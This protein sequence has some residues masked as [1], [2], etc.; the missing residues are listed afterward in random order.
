M[1][2]LPEDLRAIYL[3]FG[4]DLPATNGEDSWALPLATRM[5]IDREGIIRRIDSNPD[6]TRRPEPQETVTTLAGL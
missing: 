3:Q 2:T 6:Y 4:I 1:H 5:V